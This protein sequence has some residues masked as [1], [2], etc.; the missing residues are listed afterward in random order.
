M[1][2]R[3]LKEGDFVKVV[4]FIDRAVGIAVQ[5]QKSSGSK[6]L[7]DFKA[8]CEGNADIEALKK[9]VVE[10]SSTFPLPSVN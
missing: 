6:L 5:I 1:T 2:S 4:D 8:A 9:E 7:K 3:G 10:F